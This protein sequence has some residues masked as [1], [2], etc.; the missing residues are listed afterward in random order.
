MLREQ[1]EDGG[2][3]MGYGITAKGEECYVADGG[4]IANAAS[5]STKMDP[6]TTPKIQGF[7]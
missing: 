1:R 7:T 5:A 3:R 6:A 2:Y 4:E